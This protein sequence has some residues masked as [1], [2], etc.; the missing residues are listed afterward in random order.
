MDDRAKRW[1]KMK[2]ASFLEYHQET[3]DDVFALLRTRFQVNA[4]AFYL[5]L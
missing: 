4:V 5:P 2:L 3:D 1:T